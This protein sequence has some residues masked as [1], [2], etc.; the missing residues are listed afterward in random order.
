MDIADPMPKTNLSLPPIGKAFAVGAA[1]QVFKIMSAAT[2]DTP[3]AQ[4]KNTVM[5]YLLGLMVHM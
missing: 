1:H 5:P 4:C 2:G 3:L